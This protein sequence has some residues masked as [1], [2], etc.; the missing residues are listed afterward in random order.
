[1]IK[2]NE[3][4]MTQEEFQKLKEQYEAQGM[5]VKEVAPSV[6]KTILRG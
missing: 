5:I 6:Y 3:K 4:E 2:L 1:M